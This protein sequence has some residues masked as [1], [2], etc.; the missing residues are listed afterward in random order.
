MLKLFVE[1]L[2]G[3]GV[4]DEQIIFINFEDLNNEELL[5]YK[6][7]Y[8]NINQRLCEGKRT[9]IL[10]D[11]VQNVKQFQ[12]VVDSLYVQKNADIYITGSNAYMLSG[13]LATLLSG[14]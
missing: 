13:K 10:L 11:E 7:L 1:H 3:E 14:R 2:K 12:K 5:D 9:Y 8:N 6:C 4:S